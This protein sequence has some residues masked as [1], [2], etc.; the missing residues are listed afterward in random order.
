MVTSKV[1]HP[2]MQLPQMQTPQNWD[3]LKQK[4]NGMLC[5]KY[6]EP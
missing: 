1:V 6:Q 4:M 3:I 5:L 2:T